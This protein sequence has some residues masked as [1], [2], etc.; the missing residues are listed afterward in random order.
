MVGLPTM[1]LLLAIMPP[2]AAESMT[3]PVR[4]PVMLL[5]VRV[6]MAGVSWK[7]PR[8][9]S[10]TWLSLKRML[11]DVAEEFVTFKPSMRV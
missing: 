5:Q 6:G 10:V 1:L 8:M 7:T 9:P 4:L 3:M 2:V 11:G